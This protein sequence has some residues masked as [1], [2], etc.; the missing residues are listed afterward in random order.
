MPPNCVWAKIKTVFAGFRAVAVN[1]QQRGWQLVSLFIIGLGVFLRTLRYFENTSLYMDEAYV[2]LGFINVSWHDLFAHQPIFPDQPQRALGFYLIEKALVSTL[3]NH[4]LVLRLFPFF[5]GILSLPLFNILCR[6]YLP[7]AAA[8]VALLFF[9]LSDQLIYFSAELK[10]YSTDVLVTISLFLFYERFRPRL[11]TIKGNV[12]LGEVGSVAI[13]FSHTSI[14][15]LAG[16]GV[17]RVARAFQRRNKQA[18][19]LLLIPAV[20][21]VVNLLLIY[22]LSLRNMSKNEYLLA[23]WQG[24]FPPPGTWGTTVLWFTQSFLRIFSDPLGVGIPVVAVMFFVWGSFLIYRENKERF[25]ILALPLVAVAGATLLHK[26]PFCGRMLLFV[27]PAV[28]MPMTY[29]LWFF[30]QGKRLRLM[31]GVFLAVVMLSPSVLC[32]GK[33]L[34]ADNTISDNRGVLKYLKTRARP[35]DFILM[36]NNGRYPFLYYFNQLELWSAIPLRAITADGRDYWATPLMGKFYDQPLVYRG[37]YSQ[38]FF[39]FE[40]YVFTK[41]TKL[42]Y[43]NL[44]NSSLLK[45]NFKVARED[46]FAL[47]PE[48]RVWVF[49]SQLKPELTGMILD[50]L[51]RQGKMLDKFESR[52]AV[53]YLY[54]L[55]GR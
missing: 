24:A 1:D 22:K 42:Y 55:S 32:A 36:N 37:N 11:A 2:A 40:V 46:P 45:Q 49:L 7:P 18:L 9:A 27:L 10:Q 19:G 50:S 30:S 25:I 29:G 38:L 44:V 16:F 28:I 21:W 15:V 35:D 47:C 48:P 34:F 3:G 23:G 17:A 13:W 4:E 53:V 51:N 39:S 6:K 14:F 8:T 54:D 41:E 12:R 5:S 26:Y 52:G 33:N 31:S 20:M 43:R